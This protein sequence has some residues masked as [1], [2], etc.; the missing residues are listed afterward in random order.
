MARRFMPVAAALI[1]LILPAVKSH[2]WLFTR[3]RATM[4][5]SLTLPFRER[6]Q[7]A[8]QVRIAAPLATPTLLHFSP[9]PSSPSSLSL[10]SLSLILLAQ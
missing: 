1:L 10:L 7:S 8:G 4:Q 6:G 2:T 9:L 3:G 5:A